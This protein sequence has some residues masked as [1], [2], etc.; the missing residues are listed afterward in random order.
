MHTRVDELCD[1]IFR[2]ST[3]AADGADGGH[4]Y[5]IDADEPLLVHTSDADLHA[6]AGAIEQVMPSER[7]RW[8]CLGLAGTEIDPS[9]DRWLRTSPGV[10][11]VCH[12]GSPAAL[13][14]WAARP[15]IVVAPGA[16]FEL[17]GRTLELIDAGQLLGPGAVLL[18]ETVTATLLTGSFG[19]NREA[20]ASWLDAAALDTVSLDT[21]SLD[22]TSRDTSVGDLLR[23]LAALRPAMMLAARGAPWRGDLAAA[24]T[25]LADSSDT[26]AIGRTQ[27]APPGGCTAPGATSGFDEERREQ[28]Q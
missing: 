11:I 21:V 16:R 23:R 14:G 13:E 7:V 4:D 26:Y 12:A 15:A 20:A 18:C 1:G 25:R 10:T 2:L 28:L 24:L 22:S 6:V 27:Y 3:H 17:G 9:C 8:L 19:A 5:L